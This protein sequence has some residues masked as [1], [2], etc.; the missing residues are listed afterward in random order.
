MASRGIDL[1]SLTRAE[2]LVLATGVA[3]FA[4]GFAPW[5]FRTATDDGAFTYNAGLT[6]WSVVAVGA[7]AF[8][9]VAVLARAWI[10]PQ[11]APA[12]D[13]T[14]Y[15]LL[16]L[17]ATGAIVM[18]LVTGV[19]AWIGTWT[20]LALAVVMLGGGLQRRIERARGWT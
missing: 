2:R 9:A 17:V 13:G 16:A 11:P 6:G 3:L 1:S 15:A 4:S 18:E 10:W 14:L 7:A 20:G 5:W 8:A 12:K 19:G